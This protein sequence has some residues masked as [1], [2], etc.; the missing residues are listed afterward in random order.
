M[1]AVHHAL[2]PAGPQAAHIADF[3]WVMFAAC[4]VVFVAMMIA[5][6]W[7]V[8]RA[9]RATADMLH[10]T[11]TARTER[12]AA[13]SV[14]IALTLS[15]LA[16]LGLL[17]G[18]VMTDRALAQ[19]PRDDAVNIRVTGHDWWWEVTYDDAKPERIFTTANELHIP[20]GRPIIVTLDAADVIHSFWVPSL[21]GKKDL[22]PGRV[23][24]LELRA[25]QPGEY[26]GQCAEFC[27]MQHAFMAF[28]VFAMPAA[29]YESWAQAQRRPAVEPAEARARRG[30]DLFL[31]G[32]CMLCHAIQGT[33]AGARKGPDLTHIASRAR[34]A[35]GRLPNTPDD[36]EQWIRDPQRIKPGVNMPA[37]PLPEADLKALVAYLE[38]LR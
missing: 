6:A 17:A 29:D 38:T 26:R 14:A 2:L 15:T 20:V 33:T 25:D 1:T 28:T 22:I 19:L 4:A 34:L 7:A 36:M 10:V 11:P 13:W 16:L 23:A 9:P 5:L 8:W 3:W 31:S 12:K 37:H 24:T 21:A 30:R 32:S 18:S 27:G 35:A